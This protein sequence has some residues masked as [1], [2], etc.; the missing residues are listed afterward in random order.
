MDL[1][2]LAASLD[3]SEILLLVAFYLKFSF[4]EHLFPMLDDS[5]LSNLYRRTSMF[6]VHDWDLDLM[7]LANALSAPLFI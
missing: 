7:H 6:F 1:L 5:E 3:T 2:A 4:Y